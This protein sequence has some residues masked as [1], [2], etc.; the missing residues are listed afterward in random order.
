MTVK[1]VS[2]FELNEYI[3]N[4]FIDD[5]E[6][7]KYYD[8]DVEVKSP[9]DAIVNVTEKIEMTYPDA[10]FYGVW[11]NGKKAGYFV[12]GAGLLI[13]FGMAVEYRS[14][15]VLA[16]FWGHI[17]STLGKTFQCC[18][19]SVNKRGISFLEKGGMKI[20]FNEITIL[21]TN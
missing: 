15:E 17:K 3:Y 4:T 19:Y 20:L 13:S 7:V 10:N 1:K 14:K 9:L 8:K 5:V 16:D 11:V 2:L 6:I 18:L 21:T 12:C